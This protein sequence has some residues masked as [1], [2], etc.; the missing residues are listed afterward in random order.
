M[1]DG[2]FPMPN[3]VQATIAKPPKIVVW[4]HFS[5]VLSAL[6]HLCPGPETLP[7][8]TYGPASPDRDPLRPLWMI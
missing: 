7:P 3:D 5:K 8:S 2:V 1:K 4:P 6:P